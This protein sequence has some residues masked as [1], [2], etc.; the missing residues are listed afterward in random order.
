MNHVVCGATM[1][2]MNWD[3]V[4]LCRL[5][6]VAEGQAWAGGQASGG[7]TCSSCLP[8][9][10]AYLQLLGSLCAAYTSAEGP[11]SRLLAVLSSGST[12]VEA[13]LQGM[14]AGDPLLRCAT[15]R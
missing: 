6:A 9:A 7:T 4:L 14:R 5:A 1:L 8:P 15:L 11:C 12:L 3:S 2:L 10:A 13:L